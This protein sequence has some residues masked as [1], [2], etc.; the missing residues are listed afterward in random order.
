METPEWIV[1]SWSEVPRKEDSLF[2]ADKELWEANAQL[3]GPGDSGYAYARGYRIG[4]QA[5]AQQVLQEEWFLDFLV[6]PIAYLYRHHVELMLKQLTLT[7]AFLVNQPLSAAEKKEVTSRHHLQKL[8]EI[9]RPRLKAAYELPAQD[10]EGIDSYIRQ[11]DQVDPDGQS[12]RYAISTKGDPSLAGLRHVN[13]IAFA[14]AME[15]L[16]NYLEGLDSHFD[17]LCDH[18]QEM[19][20]YKAEFEAECMPE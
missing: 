15:R 1:R 19:L 13:I 18:K 7:A 17:V 12:F 4:A 3:H 11:L 2:R 5:L 6:F 9:F 16:C 10:L 20:A 8:W 14:E